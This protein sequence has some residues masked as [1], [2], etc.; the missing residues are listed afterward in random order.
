[1]ELTEKGIPEGWVQMGLPGKVAC[2]A[3]GHRLKETR[4]WRQNGLEPF[5]G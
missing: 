5:L 2:P 1:M 3:E 4:A